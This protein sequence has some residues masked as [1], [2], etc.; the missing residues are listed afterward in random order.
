LGNFI[1][2][3]L[4]GSIPSKKY[5]FYIILV[6]AAV[7]AVA[8]YLAIAQETE[9]SALKN[10]SLLLLAAPAVMLLFLFAK[11]RTWKTYIVAVF[12]GFTVFN[13]A[14]LGVI[15]PS[16]YRQNPVSKTIDIVKSYNTI[17]AYNIF[18]P[19]YRFYLDRDIPKTYDAAILRQL[20]TNNKEAIIITR[21]DYIDSLKQLP[22]TEIARHRDIFE[23]PTTIIFKRNAAP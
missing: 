4:Q 23:L 3:V 21:T 2:G 11:K 13:L 15:Y 7:V 17:I 9:V 16:L 14:G 19:G 6:F 8:G 1:A 5:P 12:T 10:L 20:V 22:V 18:N